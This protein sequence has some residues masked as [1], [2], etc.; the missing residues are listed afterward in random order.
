MSA[1]SRLVLTFRRELENKSILDVGCGNGWFLST[2]AKLYP[3]GELWGLDTS[4]LNTSDTERSFRGFLQQDVVGSHGS[5]AVDAVF[6]H[7]V[8]EHIAPAVSAAHLTSI[9]AALLPGAVLVYRLSPRIVSL[10]TAQDT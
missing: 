3:H 9:R 6:S 5:P 10:G 2:L 7:Q 4:S 1:A 8:F